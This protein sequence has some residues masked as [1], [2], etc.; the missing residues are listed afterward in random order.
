M[1]VVLPVA[2]LDPPTMAETQP[3]TV[4]AATVPRCSAC[5]ARPPILGDIIMPHIVDHALGYSSAAGCS[6]P[7]AISAPFKVTAASPPAERGKI[8]RAPC[9]ES[10]GSYGADW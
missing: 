10:G 2:V 5:P 1:S 3:L 7:T 9:G 6:P 8:G 4:V